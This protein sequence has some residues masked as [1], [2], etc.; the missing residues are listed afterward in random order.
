MAAKRYYDA[1]KNTEERSFSGVPLGDISEEQWETYPDHLK[2]SIDA[3]DF[4]RKTRPPP[5]PEEEN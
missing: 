2:A 4:Y 1:S 3:A 5:A